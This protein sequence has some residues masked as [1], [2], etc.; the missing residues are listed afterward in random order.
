MGLRH[1]RILVSALL[2]CAASLLA[3]CAAAHDD[4]PGSSDPRPSQAPAKP[5]SGY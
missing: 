5:A 4:A 2:V 3:G 1:L